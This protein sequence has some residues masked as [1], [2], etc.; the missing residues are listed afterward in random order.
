MDCFVPRNDEGGWRNDEGGWRN[1]EGGWRNDEGGW[2]NDE[3]WVV[4]TLR[5]RHSRA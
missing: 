3:S 4:I 2:R 1:D 5:A